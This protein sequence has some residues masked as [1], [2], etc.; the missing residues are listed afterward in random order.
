MVDILR[1]SFALGF[2]GQNEP[3]TDPNEILQVLTKID[4]WK[5]SDFLPIIK[6]FSVFNYSLALGQC[7]YSI[8]DYMKSLSASIS[9]PLI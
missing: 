2:L 3:K 7:K 1:K 5:S 9:N 6:R 8:A 4:A